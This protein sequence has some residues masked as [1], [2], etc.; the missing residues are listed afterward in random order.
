MP[1]VVLC[2]RE[3]T[4]GRTNV[5]VMAVAGFK[6]LDFDSFHEGELAAKI[7]A[8]RGA[9]AAKALAGLG[10]LAFRLPT[11]AAWTYRPTRDGVV[12]ERGDAGADTLIA[13]DLE[14][15]E[16][17]VH[18]YESAPGLLYGAR[19]RCLRGDALQLVLW[20]PAL[21][22]VYQGRPIYDPCKPLLDRDGSTLDPSR[23]FT[24]A[25]DV[26]DMR[27]FLRSTGY[28]VVRGVFGAEEGA[29]FAREAAELRAEA[30]KGDRLSWWSKN[31]GGDEILCR[32]TRG[33]DKPMLA[34]L[35]GNPRVRRFVDLVAPAFVPRFGEGNGVTVIYKNPGVT[36]GLSD[37]P[38][39]RDCGLGGHALLCPMLI[40]S[41]FLTPVD[42]DVGDLVF[43]PGSHRSSC[44]Y[45][46]PGFAPPNAVHVVA[47]PGDMSL[48]YSDVMHAAPAPKRSDLAQYR[49]SAVTDY[50]RPDARNHRG[51]QSYNDILHQRD[52]GQIEHLTS[53][54]RRA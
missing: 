13:I 3:R 41:T 26:D 50:G 51:D 18:D 38:W 54:A 21:R 7:A 43:L 12:L 32:V 47:Q 2:L 31:A 19:V 36:E 44:G 53:V 11:G 28:L 24:A 15:W 8:G 5:R 22:A 48:H 4:R 25:A 49:I 46:D 16:G 37:L 42:P 35:Y 52:D 33:A 10:S 17:L 34:T 6:E 20:E 40:C 39:H 27:H 1:A 14:S 45:M 30:V 29:T 9:L 23:D